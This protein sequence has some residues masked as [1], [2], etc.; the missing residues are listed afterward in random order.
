ML[1]LLDI[2]E[3]SNIKVRLLNIN[4]VDLIASVYNDI[5]TSDSKREITA[6]LKTSGFHI[7]G[8]KEGELIFVLL[9]IF[10]SKP[11]S[12]FVPFLYMD[13]RAKNIKA[14]G[15]LFRKVNKLFENWKIVLHIDQEKKFITNHIRPMKDKNLYLWKNKYNG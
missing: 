9:M 15:Y 4:D 1:Q 12:A 2:K 14:S 11:K 8:F 3:N 13:T 10:G 5:Y 7:A 6:F